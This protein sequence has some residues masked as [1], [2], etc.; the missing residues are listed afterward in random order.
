MENANLVRKFKIIV[1]C[2]IVAFVV[3]IAIATVSFVQIGNIRRM[4][5][6]YEKQLEQLKAEQSALKEDLEYLQS[7]DGKDDAAREDGL[8][9]D[10]EIDV[11][12][13]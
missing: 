12:V 3:A 7:Q 1:S 9:P 2:L 4:N 10:G 8:L 5:A 11:E 6:G 13:N